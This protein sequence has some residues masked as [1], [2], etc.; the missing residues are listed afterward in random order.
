MLELIRDTNIRGYF[1]EQGG[2]LVE[3][4]LAVVRADFSSCLVHAASQL[5]NTRQVTSLSRTSV[6]S[7]LKMEVV[8]IY[9]QGFVDAGN[10]HLSY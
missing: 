5:C 6:S 3:R 2:S 1:L 7:S 10:S 9:L 4:I 8:F